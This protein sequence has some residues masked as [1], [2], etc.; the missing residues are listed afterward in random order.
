MR[1]FVD[2]GKCI[3]VEDILKNANIEIENN[4]TTINHND[5]NITIYEIVNNG[6]TYYFVNYDNIGDS[7]IMSGYII[8]K[9]LN[10]RH[11][12]KEYTIILYSENE[13]M[14]QY[15]DENILDM[16]IFSF[17]GDH[18]VQYIFKKYH[19]MRNRWCKTEDIDFNVIDDFLEKLDK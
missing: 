17:A 12:G 8:A 6:I 16:N 3:K 5:Y 14:M 4:K 7:Y 13:E 18:D 19:Y 11:N 1:P 2:I 9:Y 15:Y 10:H